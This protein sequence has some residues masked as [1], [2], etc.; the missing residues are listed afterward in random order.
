MSPYKSHWNF[1]EYYYDCDSYPGS[2]KVL[3]LRHQKPSLLIKRGNLS[4]VSAAF[5]EL[6][7]KCY[8]QQ[9]SIPVGCILT[10][11]VASSSLGRGGK[12]ID[13][14]PNLS[15]SG[16]RYP[17]PRYPTPPLDTFLPPGYPTSSEI[18]YP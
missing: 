8:L 15:V 1:C 11:A 4:V 12:G 2:R 9:D 7:N 13:T 17:T 16:Y 6:S 14:L 18:P 10:N 5:I 3:Y